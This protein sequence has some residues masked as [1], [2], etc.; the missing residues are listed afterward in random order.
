MSMGLGEPSL[1]NKDGISMQDINNAATEIKGILE[2]KLN[3]SVIE[4]SE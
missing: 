2:Q 1:K 3:N 4:I